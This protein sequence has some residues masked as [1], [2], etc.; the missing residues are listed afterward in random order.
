VR[1]DTFIRL[2][3]SKP[4]RP[5]RFF[6]LE[7]T[8]FEVRH[9]EVALVTFSEVQLYEPAP[10]GPPF[11]DKETVVALPHITRIELLPLSPT[12]GNGAAAPA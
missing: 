7:K 9:P 6:V 5:F 11:S 4:F 8:E 1:P 2:L 3:R 10:A 12:G